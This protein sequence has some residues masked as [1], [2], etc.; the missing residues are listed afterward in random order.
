M[1]KMMVRPPVFELPIKSAGKSCSA[2]RGDAER[3]GNVF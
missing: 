3:T 2:E 1:N